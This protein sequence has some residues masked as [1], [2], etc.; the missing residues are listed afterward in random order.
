MSD[1]SKYIHSVYHGAYNIDPADIP[2]CPVCDQPMWAGERIE[3]QAC[4]AGPGNPDLLRLVHYDCANPEEDEGEGE[5][6]VS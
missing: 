4:D 1:T 3:L 2:C 5:L 6:W